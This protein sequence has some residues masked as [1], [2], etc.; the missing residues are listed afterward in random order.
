MLIGF[1]P[2]KKSTREKRANLLQHNHSLGELTQSP[3]NQAEISIHYL[4][5]KLFLYKVDD[6]PISCNIIRGTNGTRLVNC[7]SAEDA[8][9]A[10]KPEGAK[11]TQRNLTVGQHNGSVISCCRVF[12]NLSLYV[13][14]VAT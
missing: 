6:L 9:A 12:C 8:P 4:S 10:L 7:A 3:A 2:N 1:L 11:F 5:E 14:L 13:R